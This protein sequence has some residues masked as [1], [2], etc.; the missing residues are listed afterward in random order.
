MKQFFAI[1]LAL[2][3]IL[4]VAA[5][6][7]TPASQGTKGQ[8]HIVWAT[9]N[10]PVRQ[11][12]V[13]LFNKLNPDL[14]LT[15]D[16]MNANREKVIVQSIGGVGPDLFDSYG[17]ESLRAFVNSGVA[18][19]VSQELGETGLDIEKDVWPAALPSFVLKG[20]AYGFPA[21]VSA[22]AVWF[23]KNHFD[24]AGIPYPKPGWTWDEL[25][26]IAAQLNKKDSRGKR[27]RFGFYFTFDNWPD[28]LRTFDAWQWSDDGVRCTL[29]SPQAI[30]AFQLLQDMMYKHKIAPSPQDE[31]S[32]STQG[33]WGSG[34][35]PFLIS[36][37]VSM[38]F[39][40]RWWL[41][42]IRKEELARRARQAKGEKVGPPLRLGVL[43]LPY[44][45]K[46]SV[47]GGARCVLVN[48]K[49]RNKE[50][51]IRFIKFLAGPDYNALLNDQADAIAPV[52][53]FSETERFLKN[54]EWP[55]EDYNHIWRE[56]LRKATPDE[57]NPFVKG[58]DLA[59]INQQLDLIKGGLKP[60][61]EALQT[62]AK[63]MTARIRRQAGLNPLL[64]QLY[65]ERTGQKP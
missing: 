61:K 47:V 24:E 44:A 32:L 20:K 45:H 49:G 35:L 54:P 36:E 55:D 33:G 65:E 31:A 17:Y 15:I 60:A 18:A 30:E 37:R 3:T 51:A 12:Q 2:M 38:A 39:G 59:P 10:N 48:G 1:S 62:A 8:T 29:D 40:G 9:D 5:W 23:N 64:C 21:N 4:S 7:L 52:I 56:T 13:D 34:G 50:A 46:A 42:L 14:I 16:P 57:I 22:N 63:N 25:V 11:A 41:N 19:D 6:L 43:E 26:R 58:T 53:S 27:V 28:I